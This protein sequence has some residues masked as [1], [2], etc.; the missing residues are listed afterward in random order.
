MTSDRATQV[1]LL[2]PTYIE[3]MNPVCKCILSEQKQA[4]CAKSK[5]MAISANQ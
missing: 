1:P 5:P 3:P 4:F 2:E